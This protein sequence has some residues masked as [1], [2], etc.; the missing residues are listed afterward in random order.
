MPIGPAEQPTGDELIALH[1]L[2]SHHRKQMDF[3]RFAQKAIAI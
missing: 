3:T 2:V 1:A